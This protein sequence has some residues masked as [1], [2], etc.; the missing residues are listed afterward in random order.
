MDL[1]TLATKLK[2]LISTSVNFNNSTFTE[3]T[4]GLSL[5]TDFDQSVSDAFKLVPNHFLIIHLDAINFPFKGSN[6]SL[7]LTGTISFF[8]MVN[9]ELST[10]INLPEADAETNLLN[11]VSV[12]TPPAQWSLEDSFPYM[13]TT[14][15]YPFDHLTFTQPNFV[16]FCNG[17]RT[18][19]LARS[20]ES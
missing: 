19:A 10:V 8:N 12:M 15:G 18:L 20:D 7:Q 11:I 9:V 13:S 6:N 14:Y 4:G 3:N 1:T 17:C 5:P 2:A 16:F